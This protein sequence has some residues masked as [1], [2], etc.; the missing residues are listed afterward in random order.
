[1][2]KELLAV[3]NGP[4]SQDLLTYPPILRRFVDSITGTLIIQDG[5]N[6]IIFVEKKPIAES[7]FSF[8]SGRNPPEKVIVATV[9]K[10]VCIDDL[11]GSPAREKGVVLGTFIASSALWA[12]FTSDFFKL[13]M[14][15]IKD[16]G[17]NA[18]GGFSKFARICTRK[19]LALD[20]QGKPNNQCIYVNSGGFDYPRY[21]GF[22]V[23]KI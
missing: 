16:Y 18:G 7:S 22:L 21:V 11:Q 4:P 15:W 6:M 10:P 14:P 9:N 13:K 19:G 5:K 2:E 17:G 20:A 1:L 12:R 3:R 8:V 23:S